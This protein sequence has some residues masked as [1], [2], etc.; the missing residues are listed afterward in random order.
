MAEKIDDT[1]ALLKKIK[2]KRQDVADYLDKNE[3]KQSRLMKTSI[4]SAALAAALTAGPGIGGGGF[5][6]AL[7][8][9]VSFGIPIW[10][11]LCL[12]A[13]LLSVAAVVANGIL[14]SYNL[15]SKIAKVRSCDAKLEGLETMLE[16]KQ[17]DV[18][19]A[20]SRY[21][22]YLTEIPQV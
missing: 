17:I 2:A 9:V 8:G 22:Q 5:I 1:D 13:T 21:T 4:V 7:K 11:V 14:K 16:L 15:T 3:P 18:E 10:Q 6:N 12:V 19:Q 20:T